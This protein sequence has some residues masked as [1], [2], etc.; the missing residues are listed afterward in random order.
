MNEDYLK[1]PLFITVE[2]GDG[3]GKTAA[4]GTINHY[5]WQLNKDYISTREPGGSVVAEQIRQIVVNEDPATERI[6]D[7]TQVALFLAARKQHL[8]SKILPA[9]VAGK[10]VIC[11]RYIDSTH[12]F[13]GR[14]K[15][16]FPTI[17]ALQNAPGMQITAVRP[18]Y[19]FF[20]DVDREVALSRLDARDQNGLDKIHSKNNVD[21]YS[22]WRSHFQEVMQ[23]PEMGPRIIVID[24]SQ[25][26][27][28]VQA[29]V[30]NGLDQIFTNE[31][32]NPLPHQHFLDTCRLM[33]VTHVDKSFARTAPT[34]KYP[35]ESKYRLHP[36]LSDV[37]KYTLNPNLF[38]D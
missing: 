36:I 35:P 31:N 12:V 17:H 33:E 6:D 28:A 1:P 24:A 19:T 27:P 37:G 9:L 14:M 16:M 8:I 10:S 13:Q 18:D 3:A 32:V 5:F 23:E 11:D 25:D 38:G 4:I 2:G 20:F 30:I 26:W 34:S 15:G 29:Q 22:L 21:V 7:S